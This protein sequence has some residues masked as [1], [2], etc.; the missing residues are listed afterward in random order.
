MKKDIFC[1]TCK[2]NLPNKNMKTIKGCVWCDIKFWYSK[3]IKKKP[4]T[5]IIKCDIL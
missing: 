2:R 5:S 1:K 3:N 4:L